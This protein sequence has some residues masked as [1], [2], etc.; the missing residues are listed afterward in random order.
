MTREYYQLAS[1]IDF[2][3]LLWNWTTHQGISPGRLE[4]RQTRQFKWVSAL[5]PT[6]K[7]F[8]GLGQQPNYTAAVVQLGKELTSVIQDLDP[9]HIS[10][11]KWK[12][13]AI[14]GLQS[15]S[16]SQKVSEGVP[17]RYVLSS[18]KVAQVHPSAIALTIL[19]S[20][21]TAK[22]PSPADKFPS[23][24]AIGHPSACQQYCSVQRLL[25]VRMSREL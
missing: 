9:W 3:F 6:H 22:R 14:P 21:S 19:A 23:S 17:S 8:L 7:N 11:L 24:T 4:K 12:P 5:L 20:S 1:L 18:R 15:R 2:F 16:T 10:I 25:G 13:L